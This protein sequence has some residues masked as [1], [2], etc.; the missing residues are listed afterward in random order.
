MNDPLSVE[1][2][3]AARAKLEAWLAAT[4]PQNVA[5]YADRLLVRTRM[6]NSREGIADL[7]MLRGGVEWILHALAAYVAVPTN[8]PLAPCVIAVCL[9]DLGDDENADRVCD[10]AGPFVQGHLEPYHLAPE[11]VR[12]AYY[13]WAGRAGLA[14]APETEGNLHPSAEGRIWYHLH[15]LL[16]ASD[17]GRQLVAVTGM[18][19]LRPHLAYFDTLVQH[20]EISG[21]TEMIAQA[22]FVEAHVRPRREAIIQELLLTLLRAIEAASP[23]ASGTPAPLDTVH[24]TALVTSLGLYRIL[25][26]S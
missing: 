22:L 3:S 9:R 26:T 8:E 16:V 7:E 10:L 25:A 5:A 6:A 15:K 14:A 1:A 19:E 23:L 18:S 12:G 13:H 11:P 2:L 24:R 20:P 17:H 4:T 21:S